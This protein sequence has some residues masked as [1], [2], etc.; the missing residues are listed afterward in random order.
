MSKLRKV[1]ASGL[2]DSHGGA[3]V[4]IFGLLAIG[5]IL[6]IFIISLN[7]ALEYTNKNHSKPLVDIATHAA[8]LDFD[9]NEAAQGRITWDPVK[10]TASFYSYLRKN[11][12]LDSNNYPLPGSYLTAAPIVHYLGLVSN[13]SYPFIYSKNVT[14]H[15]SSTQQV[16]RKI[17]ATLY[18]PSV[19][20]IVEVQQK[21]NGQATG[22]PIVISSISSIRNRF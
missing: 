7:I 18:G 19:V 22:E 2:E 12:S 9:L 3:H 8:A 15:P 20:A 6:I 10:G 13:S 11:L 1:I 4:Y 16:V 21:M 14:L 17:Q 5:G